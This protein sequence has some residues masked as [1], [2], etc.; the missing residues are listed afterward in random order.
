M[1]DGLLLI[2][3][4]LAVLLVGLWRETTVTPVIGSRI[5]LRGEGR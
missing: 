3:I 5:N 2:T 4:A 1:P